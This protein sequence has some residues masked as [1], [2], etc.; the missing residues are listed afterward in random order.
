MRSIR[1]EL[2]LFRLAHKS[3]ENDT[4]ATSTSRAATAKQP[5]QPGITLSKLSGSG[6]VLNSLFFHD[7]VAT[8][9]SALTGVHRR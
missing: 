2:L 8:T 3:R 9:G 7:N 5:R 4:T 6:Q 1:L